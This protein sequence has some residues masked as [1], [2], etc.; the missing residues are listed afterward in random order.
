MNRF[1]VSLSHH[2]AWLLSMCESRVTI[3][4][5]ATGNT[6][7]GREKV[8]EKKAG[9]PSPFSRTQVATDFLYNTCE[10]RR[11]SRLLPS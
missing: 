4:S 5:Q 10:K 11:E 2:S 3:F 9:S 7:N 6:N 8:P 1:S